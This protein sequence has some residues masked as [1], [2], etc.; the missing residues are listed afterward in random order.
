MFAEEK[1]NKIESRND[2]EGIKGGI[3]ILN[4]YVERKEMKSN[5]NPYCLALVYGMELNMLLF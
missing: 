5:F 4:L 3:R 1:W 2:L